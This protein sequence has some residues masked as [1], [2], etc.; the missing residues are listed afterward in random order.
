L[1]EAQIERLLNKLDPPVHEPGPME[2]VAAQALEALTTSVSPLVRTF[3]HD[4]YD[5][6]KARVTRRKE[7]P[8]VLSVGSSER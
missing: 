8:G 4:L 6:I 5:S 7:V 1:S 3:L 2:R